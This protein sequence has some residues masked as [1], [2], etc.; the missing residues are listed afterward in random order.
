MAAGASEI[1]RRD[2]IRALTAGIAASWPGVVAAQQHAH[3]M[4]ASDAPASFQFFDA[5]SAAEVEAIAAQIIPAG[6]TPGAREAGVVYF[7]D[8]A[9]TTFDKDKQA[10]YRR[11][12][13]ALA[14][15]R[16]AMFP[17][18]KS[19]A[20]LPA[21][22]R[23]ALLGAIETTSFFDLVRVHTVTGFFAN[24]SYGGNRGLAGWKLIGFED[25]FRFTPPFGYYDANYKGGDA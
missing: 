17:G 7:I 6:E 10:D 14:E 15:K 1:S 24:P 8:R 3:R 12:L 18:S 22:D 25:T 11:G 16:Q 9:L 20:S 21:A 2:W 5:A 23:I 13:A 4:A 19:F